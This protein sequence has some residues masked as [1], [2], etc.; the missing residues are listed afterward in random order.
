MQRQSN[1]KKNCRK[2]IP[3][4]VAN[5]NAADELYGSAAAFDFLWENAGWKSIEV[6]VYSFIVVVSYRKAV[7]IDYR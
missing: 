7:D 3:A 1:Y 5:N 6:L 2:E 4:A